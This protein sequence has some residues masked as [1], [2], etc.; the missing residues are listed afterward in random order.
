LYW[1]FESEIKKQG[2][3]LLG[4]R[5]VPVNP[6]VIGSIAAQTEPYIMQIFIGRGTELSDHEFNIKLFCARKIAE[7]TYQIQSFLRLR[8][9]ISLVF[10]PIL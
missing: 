7:H 1:C 5:K 10:L 9:F 8:I 3:R 6:D 2:L 4:W